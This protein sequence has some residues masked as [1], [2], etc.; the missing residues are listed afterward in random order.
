MNGLARRIVGLG[1]LGLLAGSIVAA[2]GAPSSSSSAATPGVTAPDVT[3]APGTAAAATPS[4]GLS[5]SL[6]GITGALNAIDQSLS[7]ANAGPTGGE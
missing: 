7:G 3:T 6:S 4:D 5:S 1:M 2:C